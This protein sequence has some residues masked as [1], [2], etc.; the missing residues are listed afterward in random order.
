[1]GTPSNISPSPN[2][3]E[4]RAKLELWVQEHQSLLD[5]LLDAYCVVDRSN[6]VTHF[7]V[8]FTELCGESYRKVTKIGDFCSLVHTEFCPDRC[9]AKQVMTSPKAIRWD[10][11]RGASKAFPELNMIL[12]GVPIKGSDGRMLGSLITIRN[13]TAEMLL[14]KKYDERKRESLIDGLTGLFN[15]VY[16][17]EY[18][19]GMVKT[20]LRDSI[21]MSVIMCDVDFF[22]KV[23]DTHGHQ[24]GDFVL[25]RVAQILKSESRDTDAVGRVGGEEFMAV[26]YKN[27]PV[28]ARTFA[29]RFRK[30][31][32]STVISYQ[33]TQIPITISIGTASFGEIWK[34]G[35][36]PAV[37]AK[38][39]I[40]RAD[41]ALY[42]A[43]RGGRNRSCQWETLP[44]TD[45]KQQLKKAS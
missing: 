7:N 23:N 26:L 29:E 19:A 28:G 37:I 32:E 4:E 3:A 8:A 15:K 12:S 38:D 34:P 11:V 13:V 25:T 20:S 36:D 9:P 31:V 33:G 35:M 30:H 27:D 44:A 10:E 41:A 45:Q 24:A 5:L 40:R 16:A 18:L 2:S 22:K 42:A 21:P 43:K 1:M 14:Q 39:L 6:R 17:E